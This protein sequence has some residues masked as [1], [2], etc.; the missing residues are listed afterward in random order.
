[1]WSYF[2]TN[3]IWLNDYG[4][5]K[6]ELWLLIDCFFT[7]PLLCFYCYWDD[8][9]TAVIKTVVYMSLLVLLGSILIPQVE[10]QV[11]IYLE[12]IRYVAVAGFLLF[13]IVAVLTVVLAIKSAFERNQDPDDSIAQPLIKLMGGQ[14]LLTSMMQVEAR[15]WTFLLF[16]KQIKP[17]N[18]T[19][20][21]FHSHL[22]DGVQ[23]TLLGFIIITCIE[24]PILHTLL[25]FIWSPYAANVVSLLTLISLIYFIAQYRAIALRPISVTKDK[26]VIRYSLSNPLYISFS[27][28]ESVALNKHSVSR[29]KDTIRY[30][31]FGVPNVLITL[32]KSKDRT[33]HKIYLGLNKPDKFVKLFNEQN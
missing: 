6:R 21:H 27:E 29:H 22:K 2:Y 13:E 18:F 4:S 5:D 15:V 10:K 3:D 7:L 24:I 32:K 12:N 31:L 8:K 19:G 1:M 16:A 25:Y 17:E 9:K 26:V 23:S 11:W 28:V 20:A 33:F 30:N 14:S